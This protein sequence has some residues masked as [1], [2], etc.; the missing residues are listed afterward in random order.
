MR[1]ETRKSKIENGN[2]KV[3]KRKR[4]LENGT[5]KSEIR[6]S[7]S[8]ALSLNVAAIFEFRV[9]NSLF[10]FRL[11]RVSSFDFRFLT[12]GN[13]LARGDIL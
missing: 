12:G 8:E 5:W 4:K 2:S 13:A 11:S 1:A 6:K 9:S 7:R 10:E 3:E